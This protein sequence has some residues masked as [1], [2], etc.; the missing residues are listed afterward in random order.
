MSLRGKNMSCENK[1]MNIY[2]KLEC[3][4]DLSVEMLRDLKEEIQEDWMYIFS[5]VDELLKNLHEIEKIIREK[6]PQITGIAA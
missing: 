2:E 5:S 6:L 4:A 3:L 1:S